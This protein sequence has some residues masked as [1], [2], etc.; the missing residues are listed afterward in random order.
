M[1]K[2]LDLHKINKR[3]ESEFQIKIQQFLDSGHYILGQ[4]VENFERNFAAYCDTKYCVGTSN[5]L[6]ALTLIFKAF[7][8]LGKLKEGDEVIIPANTF[9]ASVLSVINAGL[10]PVFVEPDKKTFSI[11]VK[12]I[13]KVCTSKVKAIM[14]VH[15]YGQLAN[16]EAINTFAKAHHLVV[17]EDAAQAHGAENSESKKAGNLSDAAAFSFYPSK[18]LGALGDGGAVTT[19]NLVLAETIKKLHNYGSEKKYEYSLVGCNNRLDEIQAI[20]LNIK[21]KH[22][23]TDNLKRQEIAKRYLSEIKNEKVELPFY[24]NS[25]NHVF[26]LFVVRVKH[27]EDFISYL[28]KQKIE[29]LIHYPTPPH[30][31]KALSNFNS[32]SLPITEEIHHTV[33]SI[34]ISPVMT[35][36]EITQ[37]INSINTY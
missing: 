28:K 32:L 13:E 19:N 34:P 27:R 7:I 16:M 18:N 26:H 5:G 25:Q 30:K 20:F 8:H 1:I 11:S 21:L 15:L 10:I 37:I 29:T 31:Q 9:F 4:E 6:D 17:V 23:D 12:E 24:N 14:A 2:F 33:V 22:L 36:E 3:F 35:N